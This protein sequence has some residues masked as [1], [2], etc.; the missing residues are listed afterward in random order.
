MF[1]S[2]MELITEEALVAYFKISFQD[3]PGGTEKTSKNSV[4]KEM[5]LER[6]RTI[7]RNS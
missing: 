7:R 6:M 3:L 4:G 1:N 2:D 5:F